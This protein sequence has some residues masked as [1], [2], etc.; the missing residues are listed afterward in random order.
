MLIALLTTMLVFASVFLIIRAGYPIIR[1]FFDVRARKD[2]ARFE[3]WSNELYL[4]WSPQKVRQVAYAANLGII[5]VGLLVLAVSSRLVFAV[6]ASAAA[7]FVPDVSVPSLRASTSGKVR[8]TI[9]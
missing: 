1:R 4:D 8:G 5:F 3:A 7:V 2:M 9:A 6:A